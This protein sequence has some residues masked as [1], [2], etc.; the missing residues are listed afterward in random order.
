MYAQNVL[1]KSMV[2]PNSH[3]LANADYYENVAKYEAKRQ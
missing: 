1:S 2:M 3:E